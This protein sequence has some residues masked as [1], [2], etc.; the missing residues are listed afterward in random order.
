MITENT[1]QL[2]VN[3]AMGRSGI[4]TANSA[5]AMMEAIAVLAADWCGGADALKAIAAADGV[6]RKDAAR[7]AN[8]MWGDILAISGLSGYRPDCLLYPERFGNLVKTY[9]QCTHPDSTLSDIGT[10]G[11]HIASSLVD[12]LGYG[13]SV[14]SALEHLAE[15]TACLFEACLWGMFEAFP[16]SPEQELGHF[17]KEIRVNRQWLSDVGMSGEDTSEYDNIHDIEAWLRYAERRSETLK[18]YVRDGA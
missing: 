13:Y 6:S 11:K 17:E 7:A 15:A 5:E 2:L 12:G 14:A 8:A 10:A 4:Y 16:M 1:E 18:Q 3:Q 9:P